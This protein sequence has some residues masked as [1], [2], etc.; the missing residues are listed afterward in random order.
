MFLV[1][2]YTPTEALSVASTDDKEQRRGRGR[3]DHTASRLTPGSASSKYTFENKEN[4]DGDIQILNFS[5][6]S[7]DIQAKI[8]GDD[9]DRDTPPAHLFML[10][11]DADADAEGNEE[12]EVE[13]NTP[14]RPLPRSLD[15]SDNAGTSKHLEKKEK[16][17][18]EEVA[19]NTP[20]RVH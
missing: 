20:M 3:G 11:A 13:G 7:N 6:A 10:I 14:K 8:N 5:N 9:K 18:E 17:Q 1:F 19:V 15:T 12:I 2:S 4:S 16:N